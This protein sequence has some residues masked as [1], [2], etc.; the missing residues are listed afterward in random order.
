MPHSIAE[1]DNSIEHAD[2]RELI[3][4]IRTAYG[5]PRTALCCPDAR[6]WSI[7]VN[8]KLFPAFV[9]CLLAHEYVEKTCL[10]LEEQ[11]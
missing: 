7:R 10:F 5:A 2:V 11:R 3:G 1:E 8:T 9:D 6:P 4:P